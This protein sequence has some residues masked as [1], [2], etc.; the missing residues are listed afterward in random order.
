MI[1][2]TDPPYRM[3]TCPDNSCCC[4]GLEIKLIGLDMWWLIGLVMWWLIE[5][6][7]WWLIEL[8]MW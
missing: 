5:L 6:V 3:H 2:K 4:I 7:M 1:H 8:V